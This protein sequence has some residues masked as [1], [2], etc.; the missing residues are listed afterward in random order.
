MNWL[1]AF[2]LVVTMGVEAQTK[3]AL[4]PMPQS[5]QWTNG[6]FQLRSCK[7]IVVKDAALQKEAKLL[8]EMINEAGV[9]PAITQSL[10]KHNYIEIKLGAVKSLLQQNEAYR[11]QVASNHIQ[12]TAN[13]AHGI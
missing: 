3:P 1:L 10:V 4:I 6:D 11:L 13:T 7:S 5:L 8:Q 2:C 9:K 12:I